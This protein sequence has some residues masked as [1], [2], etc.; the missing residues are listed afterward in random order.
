[1]QELFRFIDQQVG[2]VNT[3]IL[4]TSDHGIC[5]APEHVTELGIAAERL[6]APKIMSQLNAALQVKFNTDENLALAFKKPGIYLDLDAINALDLDVAEVERALAAKI[7]QN[8]GFSLALTKTD[9]LTGRVPDTLAARRVEAGFHP[10]RS[11][12]VIVVQDQFWYL[13]STPD[14]DTAMH[15]SPYNYDSHVPIMLAGPRI[16]QGKVDRRVAPRDVAPTISAYLGIS[17][18]SGAVGNPL[19]G[20]GEASSHP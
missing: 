18:P 13:S 19:P 12:N 11:G 16:R 14:G 8:P 9:I 7:M 5:P 10:T 15:G 3:L 2:L 20:I 17:P 4:L 1:M 6:D